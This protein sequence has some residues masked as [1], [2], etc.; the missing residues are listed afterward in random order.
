MHMSLRSAALSVA[1]VG[2]V[3][4]S[5][6]GP[7]SSGSDAGSD[8]GSGSGCGFGEPN[9]TRETAT[10]LAIDAG[11]T[12]ACVGTDA[13]LVDFYEFTAP[14]DAS[15]GYVTVNFTN[16][17]AVAGPEAEIFAAADNGEIA[18]KYEVD[19]GKSLT[20]WTTVAPAAKYRF[21]IK[22]FAGSSA[23]MSY[24]VK[25]NYTKLPDAFEPNNRKEDAKAI[26]VGTAIQA[27]VAGVSANSTLAAGDVE[28]WY[29]VTVAAGTATI[30]MSNVPADYLC[31]M[32]VF[33]A[34]GT[35]IDSKY[36][37]TEGANCQ[38]DLVSLVGGEIKIK[39]DKFAGKPAQGGGGTP[40]PSITS[41]YTLLVSQP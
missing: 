10:P 21:T 7:T 9:G 8:A 27:S 14:D 40:G 22:P 35:S 4:G 12:S 28:D 11:V 29:K 23:P 16:V 33:D 5:A 36:N 34:S 30:K 24:D 20:V 2:L 1:A 17:G 37:T 18:S 39:L 6:C 32:E 3:L 38:L 25:L 31:Q 41:Q 19:K 13:D 15:G 26:T